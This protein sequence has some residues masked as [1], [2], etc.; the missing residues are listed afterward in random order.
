MVFLI[1]DVAPSRGPGGAAAAATGAINS[2]AV[3]S[4]NDLPDE[5]DDSM[6]V[7]SKS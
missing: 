7:D 5:D 6:A 4:A 1:R 3:P 2:A